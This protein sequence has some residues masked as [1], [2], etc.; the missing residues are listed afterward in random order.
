MALIGAAVEDQ[1]PFG[2]TQRLAGANMCYHD[3]SSPL[4]VLH[5]L[6]ARCVVLDD[7]EYAGGCSGNF[8]GPSSASVDAI[9]IGI[10]SEFV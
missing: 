2:C 10:R 9:G 4:R 7:P 8:V 6:Y 5:G 1:G 3:L